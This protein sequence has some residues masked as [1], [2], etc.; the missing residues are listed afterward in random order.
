MV[1]VTGHVV[2]GFLCLDSVSL[3]FFKTFITLMTP[4]KMAEN[5]KTARM[6]FLFFF[7]W[8]GKMSVVDLLP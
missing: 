8:S 4:F 5:S 6:N 3:L 1:R 7:F 2:L